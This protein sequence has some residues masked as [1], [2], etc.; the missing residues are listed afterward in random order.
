MAAQFSISPEGDHSRFRRPTISGRVRAFE[1]DPDRQRSEGKEIV[2][3]WAW[4]C[5]RGQGRGGRRQP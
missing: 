5:R 1:E 3:V 2:V 4:F